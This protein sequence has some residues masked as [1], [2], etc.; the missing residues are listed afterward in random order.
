MNENDNKIAAG[1]TKQYETVEAIGRG[2]FLSIIH[3][4]FLAGKEHE[5]IMQHTRIG[6][7]KDSRARMVE[8]LNRHLAD[9]QY[10]QKVGTNNG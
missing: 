6:I 4:S 10:L 8:F 1:W 3:K 9:P 7:N 2:L 5:R